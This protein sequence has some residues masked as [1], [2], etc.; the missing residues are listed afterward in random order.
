MTSYP[1]SHPYAREEEEEEEEGLHLINLKCKRVA[2][3]VAMACSSFPQLLSP[4]MLPEESGGRITQ[5]Q[6][7]TA[8]ITVVGLRLR[9]TVSTRQSPLTTTTRLLPVR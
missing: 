2:V 5:S 6:S 8:M 4:A 3:D 1:R 7:L 9:A